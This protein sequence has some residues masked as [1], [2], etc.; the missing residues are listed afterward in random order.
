MV[1]T[2]INGQEDHHQILTFHDLELQ[3]TQG[4]RK[5]RG[6][7]IFVGEEKGQRKKMMRREK[8]SEFSMGGALL[9]L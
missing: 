3:S 9:S 7:E 8:E 4:E 6:R 5:G 1:F 2:Q